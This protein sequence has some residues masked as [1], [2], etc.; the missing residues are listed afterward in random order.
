LWWHAVTKPGLWWVTHSRE[1]ALAPH[2]FPE[3]ARGM[4]NGSERGVLFIENH[5]TQGWLIFLKC[6]FLPSFL[7]SPHP[8]PAFPI[9]RSLR[10]QQSDHSSRLL[11]GFE[12]QI[13]TAAMYLWT[14]HL[15]LLTFIG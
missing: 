11:P 5:E 2:P 6:L 7:Y 4:W 9:L 14:S 3:Q 1:D 8:S 10:T 13:P 15:T 12:S